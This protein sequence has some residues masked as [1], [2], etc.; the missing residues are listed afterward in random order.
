M[1]RAL[2]AVAVRL[3][4]G[5][6][7]SW[8]AQA[9]IRFRHAEPLTVVV[10]AVPIPPPS[11]PSR[12]EFSEFRMFPDGLLEFP[13]PRSAMN[14]QDAHSPYTRM[15]AVQEMVYSPVQVQSMIRIGRACRCLK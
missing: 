15:P 5:F 6:V 7:D 1:L 8:F 9:F 11:I 13:D 2:D 12:T 3:W 10:L 14:V 4:F